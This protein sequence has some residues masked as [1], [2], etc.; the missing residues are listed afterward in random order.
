MIDRCRIFKHRI[1]CLN[2]IAAA[3]VMAF[4]AGLVYFALALIYNLANLYCYIFDIVF[5]LLPTFVELVVGICI[6]ISRCKLHLEWIWIS[7]FVQLSN[8]LAIRVSPMTTY[9]HTNCSEEI[10]T[11]A[12]FRGDDRIC[13]Y[14]SLNGRWITYAILQL[15]SIP[16]FYCLVCCYKLML[17]KKH[18][19]INYPSV[20][21]QNPV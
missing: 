18:T 8:F 2:A 19:R 3:Q 12:I 17:Y 16:V 5:L 11:C 21:S 20:P 15:P 9:Q 1:C 4:L 10:Y 7:I 13:M 6:S 14:T